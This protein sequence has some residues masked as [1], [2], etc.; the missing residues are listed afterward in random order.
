M[1]AHVAE[2]SKKYSLLKIKLGAEDSGRLMAVRNAAPS[3]R[4]IV[5]ANEGW[6]T[7]NLE[8]ML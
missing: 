7:E 3:A 4:L 6:S 8:T 2:A 1:A 5:D